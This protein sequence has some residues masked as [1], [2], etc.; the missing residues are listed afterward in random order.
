METT[1][2]SVLLGAEEERMDEQKDYRGF[3]LQ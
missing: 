3:S 2:R 1:K